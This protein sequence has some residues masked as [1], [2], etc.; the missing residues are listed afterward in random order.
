MDLHHTEI[1]L[2][3][4]QLM[5]LSVELGNMHNIPLL[6]ERILEVAKQ[7][8]YADGGTLYRVSADQKSLC[9]YIVFNDSLG[10]YKGGTQGSAIDLPNI[11]LLN[12]D[13]EDNLS[14][15]AAYAAHTGQSVNIP[16]VYDSELFDFSAMRQ[17][18][19][20]HY[21]VS[22]SFLAVPMR[23]H[24]GQLIGVLQLINAQN[25]VTG[26][27]HEFSATDQRFIEAL[28]SQAAIAISRQELIKRVDTIFAS[29]I[30]LISLTSKEQPGAAGKSLSEALH[31]LD[32]FRDKHHI[33]PEVF[34]LFVRQKMVVEYA[35]RLIDPV[36][37]V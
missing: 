18:D 19:E 17:F 35:K 20:Q 10:I 13:G 8:T 3:L 31:T 34:E 36:Q 27:T 11:P 2:R 4:D 9:F 22:R 15:V 23:D 7:I 26:M 29:F 14:S 21:Y 32:N 6:L 28:A 33:D 1:A 16:N 25:P 24:E 30:N 5:G 12:N 37:V